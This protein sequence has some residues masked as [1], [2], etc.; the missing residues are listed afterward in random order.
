MIKEKLNNLKVI[1]P[2]EV[3]DKFLKWFDNK[4][5]MA[6]LITIIVG[7]IT[8]ITMITEMIMS[9]DGLWNSISYS[10]AGLWETT[11]GRWGIELITRVTSFIAI[12]S[13][14]TIF[15]I[16]LMAITAV[17][18][19]DVFNLKSKISIFF[20]S[21]AL[22][23]TPTFTVTLL[24]VYTSFAYCANMLIATLVVWFIYKF[25]YKKW[26]IVLSSICF[27]MVLSIYQS[28]VGVT[29]GLCVMVSVLHLIKGEKSIKEI[30]INILK[31]VISVIAGGII[32]YIIT[33]ILLKVS[34]VEFAAYKGAN[35]I[36]IMDIILN[37]KT[38]IIQAYK[39]FL[40]FFLGDSIVYNS[41]YRREVLYGI[42][43]L[44]FGISCL[45][46]IF[47]IKSENK[48]E[49]VFR[50]VIS[51]LF[52]AL[53]PLALNIIDVIACSTTIYALTGTQL[54]LMIPFAFAIFEL[55][56]KFI[57]LKWIGVLFCV[58]IML[59]YY[60][61]TNTSYSA[62][63]LTYNQAY[64]TTVRIMDRIENT[65]GY[66]K[67]AEILFGGIVGNNNYPRTSSLYNY[68]IG[69]IVN[70]TTFH[71]T[72]AGQIGTWMSFLKVFLGVD[73]VPCSENTYYTIV[74]SQEYKDMDVFPATNSVKVLNGI[75][76]VK[77]SENPPLP[78]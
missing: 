61:A 5:K 3:L 53:L 36:S 71:G 72:Y 43:F 13:I 20:T 54:I 39:D 78:Y 66:T 38:T 9:Q 11:L 1:T 41:N 73:F 14:T 67:D 37:L 8:H 12:P 23:L 33:M 16:I 29:V 60:I 62:L 45:I 49:R 65:T 50:I 44:M 2:D 7:I 6:F 75:V 18:L 63:K 24:Y 31:T 34:G 76:V 69:S 19:V 70:N 42:F 47:S 35:N 28:Y 32:Y 55:I 46:S 22:V 4:K 59:T 58:L 52:L 27:M 48:K 21:I 74:N 26:G 68:T 40:F 17:F 64:S 57:I 51:I 30:F 10:R 56:E 15:N 25:P 77:L